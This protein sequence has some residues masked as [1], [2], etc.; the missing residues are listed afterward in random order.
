MASANKQQKPGKNRGKKRE[1]ENFIN[2]VQEATDKSIQILTDIK[3][4][5]Q[6]TNTGIFE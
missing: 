1:D 4:I 2:A 5:L 6:K 3:A